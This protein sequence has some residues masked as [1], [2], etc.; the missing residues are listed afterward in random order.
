MYTTLYSHS[1]TY[2]YTHPIIHTVTY[3]PSYTH[4]R[5]HAHTPTRTL[6]HT[7]ARSAHTADSN[8]L[9][10]HPLKHH[11]PF[12]W[13]SLSNLLSLSCLTSF[14]SKDVKRALK[15]KVT[16]AVCSDD[17]KITQKKC[18][19]IRCHRRQRLQIVTI[20]KSLRKMQSEK[21]N[22]DYL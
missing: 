2:T 4:P 3:T 14:R 15:A 12:H 9:T 8:I 22:Q 11:S 16:S 13:Q 6:M 17:I 21:R 19:I 20:E 10:Y 5:T 18:S 7:Y 1:R